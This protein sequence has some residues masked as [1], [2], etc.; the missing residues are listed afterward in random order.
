MDLFLSL[1]EKISKT[2]APLHYLD[3]FC[4]GHSHVIPSPSASRGSIAR[5]ALAHRS[6][7]RGIATAEEAAASDLSDW[8]RLPEEQQRAGGWIIGQESPH[9]RASSKNDKC[10]QS[11]TLEEAPSVAPILTDPVLAKF[12]VNDGTA[13]VLLGLF[14]GPLS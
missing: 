2:P 12:P 11:E 1:S 3:R 5:L 7:S 4:H 13:S 6:G 10:R 8:W 9:E 14:H